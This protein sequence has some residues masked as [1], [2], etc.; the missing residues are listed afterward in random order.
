MG[1]GEHCS[2]WET[3]QASVV[4]T[5]TGFPDVGAA[6]AVVQNL[7]EK[8]AGVTPWT[9]SGWAITLVNHCNQTFR[10]AQPVQRGSEASELTTVNKQAYYVL[11]N[12]VKSKKTAEQIREAWTMPDPK[13]KRQKRAA[14]AWPEEVVK[15][16]YEKCQLL[17]EKC[18]PDSSTLRWLS[19]EDV[20]K[21]PSC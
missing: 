3:F 8:T 16:R 14:A 7:M 5:I 19:Y 11:V 15:A 13:T 9:A 17:D 10:R 1:W 18:D 6:Q 20:P 4:A 12:G 2:D 21:R